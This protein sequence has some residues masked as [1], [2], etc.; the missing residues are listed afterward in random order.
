MPRSAEDFI[1]S[2]MSIDEMEAE[3]NR[4]RALEKKAKEEAEA[5]AWYESESK[6]QVDEYITEMANHMIETGR[7]TPA[8]MKEYLGLIDLDSHDGKI[9]YIK[10][11][12]NLLANPLYGIQK[13]ATGYRF[14]EKEYGTVNEVYT[15]VTGLLGR[16]EL[17]AADQRWFET[18]M[19]RTLQGTPIKD[20]SMIAYV[21]A[22]EPF[23]NAPEG[24]SH[25]QNI[26][27]EKLGLTYGLFNRLT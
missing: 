14:Q 2:N 19:T 13:T 5:E 4:Q 11:V 10:A 21:V 15:A 20:E 6:R 24:I 17:K 26:R 7:V 23:R 12:R 16:V 22:L 8:V 27:L 9:T 1:R 3:V 18:A 25:D